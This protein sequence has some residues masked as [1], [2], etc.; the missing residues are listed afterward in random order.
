MKRKAILIAATLVATAAFSGQYTL[1]QPQD[2]YYSGGYGDNNYQQDYFAD[3]NDN[4]YANYA[5]RQQDKAVGGGR[6]GW[7]KLLIAG[8]SGYVAGAK[9]HTA[10]LTKNNT[11]MPKLRFKRN[12]R[13]VCHMGSNQWSKGTVAKLWAEQEKGYWVPYQVKLDDGKMIFAP[14][15]NDMTI[16]A[17]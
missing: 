1:A 7:T 2:D 17:A 14:T 15:D 3:P 8:I 16:R 5:A 9:I 4:L 12:Q 10:R 13:V 11:N 6:F